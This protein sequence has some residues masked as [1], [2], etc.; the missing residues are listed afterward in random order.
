MS[1]ASIDHR[2]QNLSRQIVRARAVYDLWWLVAGKPTR[3][4][5]A[6]TFD[7]YGSFFLFLEHALLGAAIVQASVP[8]DRSK[9]ALSLSRLIRD[10]TTSGLLSPV[11]ASALDARLAGVSEELARVKLLRDRAVAHLM[12]RK[13]PLAF[14][15]AFTEAGLRPVDMKALVDRA[16]EV[17]NALLEA[18]GS[19]AIFPN[20]FPAQD[21]LTLLQD[22]TKMLQDQ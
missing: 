9:G 17:V 20:E 13:G 2:L 8:F 6:D 12:D 18:R 1:S 21:G 11:V 10:M 5:H 4:P 15:Q 14:N 7:Q 16:M 3:K 22:L 19:A